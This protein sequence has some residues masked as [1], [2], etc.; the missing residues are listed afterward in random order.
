MLVDRALT[1]TIR[2]LK[3][4]SNKYLFIRISVFKTRFKVKYNVTLLEDSFQIYN[5]S[6]HIKKY[7]DAI[8]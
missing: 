4:I 8:D 3:F 5:S 6:G 1:K 7:Y 2:N